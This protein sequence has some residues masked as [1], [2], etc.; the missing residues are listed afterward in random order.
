MCRVFLPLVR[1]CLI[2]LLAGLFSLA[3][4]VALR[5]L[6]AANSSHVALVIGNSGY[7]VSST[8][9]N[10]GNDSAD[11]A[12]TLAGMGYD[13]SLLQD[14]SYEEMR[15]ALQTFSGKARRAEVSLVFF[16]GHG[17]EVEKKNYLIPVDADL[18]TGHD[19]EF[20]AISLDM[21]QRAASGA[22]RLNVIILDACRDN[23]FLRAM[24]STSGAS[25]SSLPG[26]LA[27]IEPDTGTIIGFAAKEGTTA[28]D[29]VGRNSPYT[30]A[31]LKHIPTRGLDVGQMF[32]IIRDEV[33]TSTGREQE[34]FLYGSLPAGTVSLHPSDDQVATSPSGV[35]PAVSGTSTEQPGRNLEDARLA[36]E[37]VRDSN[38]ISD[39]D[40]IISAYSGTIYEQLAIGR[41][42]QLQASVSPDDP[43]QGPLG[44]ETGR[45]SW[46]LATY[47]NLDLFGGDI[48]PKGLRAQS[49]SECAQS[50]GNETA[51]RA[52]TFNAEARRC[53][54]KS[55][56]S[57]AQVFDGAVAGYYFRGGSE[58]D[59]P[60][61]RATWELFNR[62]DLSGSD[63]GSTG[64]LTFKGCMESC[65]RHSSCSGFTF[66]GFLKRNRCWLKSGFTNQ[67]YLSAN[68]RSGLISARRID[69]VVTPGRVY[70]VTAVD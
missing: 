12:E 62:R 2:L 35:T 50:C 48:H 22:S 10:P 18:K 43:G 9:A 64:D 68:T 46:F 33:L 14:A 20:Q 28:S 56:Y 5:A 40:V 53:F 1:L 66:A 45:D 69:R 70:P 55:S 8:L 3:N 67:P 26:G 27:S 61:V 58:R 47:A 42:K 15:A 24:R 44:S 63:L 37:A 49:V 57:F 17:I 34:P 36:W 19:V 25:R 21:V 13:V 39:F 54:L 31:L 65:A 30:T 38:V 16:A 41:K 4:P 51:C 11:L 23:P 29:G 59:A 6:T 60:S 52:F 7:E 32:R